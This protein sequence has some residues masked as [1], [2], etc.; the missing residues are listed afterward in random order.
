MKL[1][2]LTAGWTRLREVLATATD[3]DEIE[4]FQAAVDK[5][6]ASIQDK[7]ENLAVFVKELQADADALKAEERALKERRTA[8]ENKA[9]RL[10]DY[11]Q[12]ELKA[13]GIVRVDGTRA[14]ISF[15]HNPPHVVVKDLVALKALE[16]A[17]RPYKYDESNVDKTWLKQ[18]IEQEMIAPEL[19]ALESGES[20]VIK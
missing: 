1:Y 14:R 9:S 7:A 6:G 19:A 5:I 10:V 12:W 17:W 13:A 20:L 4:S 3:P 18:A 16:S 2:E 15:R 8:V 11:L